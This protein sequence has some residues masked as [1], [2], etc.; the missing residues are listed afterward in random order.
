MLRGMIAETTIRLREGWWYLIPTF[1]VLSFLLR[2][3]GT[4]RPGLWIRAN[5]GTAVVMFIIGLLAV[6]IVSAAFK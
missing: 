3:A 1:L 2:V 4:T 6:S 5:S